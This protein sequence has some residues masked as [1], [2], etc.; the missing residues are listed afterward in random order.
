MWYEGG[1]SAVCEEF[2]PFDLRP[3]V[4]TTDFGRT[5]FPRNVSE[6]GIRQLEVL[7]AI[8]LDDLPIDRVIP[9]RFLPKSP[10][11]GE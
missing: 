2:P 4:P 1:V 5:A 9:A 6:W 10:D 7:K 8:P 11:L 3:E